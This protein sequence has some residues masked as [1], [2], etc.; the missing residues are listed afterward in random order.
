MTLK[1]PDYKACIPDLPELIGPATA[2]EEV[3]SMDFISHL[4]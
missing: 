3:L 1:P 2:I 4:F